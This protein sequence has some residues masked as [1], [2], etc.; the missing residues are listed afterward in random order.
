MLYANKKSI[1]IFLI[2]LGMAFVV[3]WPILLDNKVFA[4][5]FYFFD[6]YP[7]LAAMKSAVVNHESLIWS[8]SLLGGF[9]VFIGVFGEYFSP[10]IS[11]LLKYFDYIKVFH[12]LTFAN[13]FL[14]VI[15]MY[16][17]VRCLNLSKPAAL[18]SA[19]VYAFSQTMLGMVQFLFFS[20]LLPVIPLIFMSVLKISQGRKKFF[21]LIVFL[22]WFSWMFGF[23]EYFLYMSAALFAFALFLDFLRNFSKKFFWEKSAATRYF[24]LA[25]FAGSILALPR[26]L[27]TY[28][29]I[30]L[31][32]RNEG[33]V[34]A[35]FM[36]LAD[37]V[38]LFFPYFSIPYDSF[39]PLLKLSS[40]SS[41]LYIGILPLLLAIIFFLEI[42]FFWRQIPIVR[43]FT[44]MFLFTFAM[45]IKFIS[46]YWIINK[47][48]AFNWFRGSAKAFFLGIF[49]VSILTGFVLDYLVI[50]RTNRFFV[51]FFLVFKYVIATVLITAF[52]VTAVIYFFQNR[53]IGFAEKYFESHLYLQA[54]QQRPLEHYHKLIQKTFKAATSNFSFAD[55]HYVF[56]LFFIAASYLVMHFFIKNK[57]SSVG[58]KRVAVVTVAL[59][60][61]FL[62]QGF[63]LLLPRDI[64]DRIPD[65]L[66]FLIERQ[67]T[68][69]PFRVFRFWG[70]L[71]KYVDLGLDDTDRESKNLLNLALLSDN[72]SLFYNLDF[73]A[74]HENIMSRR[75]AR[76]MAA[77]GSD[78]APN[79]LTWITES[80]VFLESKKNHFQSPENRALLSL[81]N[82]KY[83]LTSF[84]F[85]PPLR[86]IYNTKI[87]KSDIPVFI[88]ENPDVLP[89]VYF[90]QD[91]KFIEPN[92][93]SAFKE[94]LANKNFKKT[95]L[96][97]CLKI[98]CAH[99]RHSSDST[100]KIEIKEIKSGYL[101]L[102]T[103]NKHPRWLIYSESNLPY[104]EARINA[105]PGHAIIYSAN[106]LFQAIYIPA[107]DNTIIF[108][109]PG[110]L[111][112]MLDAFKFIS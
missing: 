110:I 57:I 30:A 62:W 63:F 69:L 5:H 38:K 36:T 37:S 100:D 77:I 71:S 112:Q 91:V 43:F 97:E 102:V 59:N 104:W 80:K 28:N 4:G 78:R 88:Y 45:T 44:V 15:F 27:P 19:L 79:Y 20:N 73:I 26:L 103:R 6:Q 56:S 1:F 92:E 93:E 35:S 68:E 46:P 95:T 107:G 3:L 90:A 76:F 11:V 9:P 50:I 101:K 2:A 81:A 33:A 108:T 70:G 67:K 12:W 89:R 23:P 47:L 85:S 66:N 72:S 31:S 106:Y 99:T 111:K 51:R 49:S 105:N 58:F 16:L 96:I 10:V 13:L 41:G 109:Y 29:F 8:S 22:V 64:I 61:A 7:R 39:I 21:F 84:R 87:T 94:L 82:V 83:L 34:G 17:F 53:L 98:E 52:S 25:L 40:D 24:L 54:T 60:F 32:V 14:A 42:K 55:Y 74:G 86:E 18:V 75:Q 48:P 65:N